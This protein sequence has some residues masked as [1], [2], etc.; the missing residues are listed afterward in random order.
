MNKLNIIFLFLLI[1][2][3]N[4]FAQPISLHPQNPHYFLFKGKPTIL[5]TSAEHYGA[6]L[7]ADFDYKKYLQTLRDEGMN[8][9]RIF[10]GSYAEVPE[11]FGIQN[12]SL[13]PAVGSFIAPWKRVDEPGLFKGEKKFDLNEWN[14]AF[15]E[16]L[17]DFISLADKLGI[18][19]EVTFFCSTYQD[20]IW[21]R[22]P[23]NP[24][25]NINNIPINLERQ[26]S[27]TIANGILTVFQQKLVQK[28]VTELNG[29]DNIFYE[30]QNEP[31]SDDPQKVMRLLKTLD[32][33]PEKGSWYK[34]AEMASPASLEWQKLMAKTVV[35]TEAQL[36]KKHIIAQNYT[37][38][39]HSL[40][41]VDPNISILN[42]HYA[43]P[44]AVWLN[45]G[46]NRPVS[47]D[48]SG[49]AGS[50]D[51]TYLRQAWQFIMAGGAVCNNL[52]YSFYVGKEDGIGTNKAPGGGSSMLRKQL[53]FLKGFI[54]SLDFVQM[55]PDFSTVVHAPGMQVQAISQPGFQYAI[56]FTGVASKSVKL[57]L[58]K[59]KYT[60]EYVS[61]YSGK[62]LKKG[63]FT[64]T[65]KGFYELKMPGFGEM[66]AL[67]IV[68]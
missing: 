27:N 17:N 12:N 45:Y 8:Y 52:D 37:N 29:F 58:P 28:L 25:N 42:F 16:R 55:K 64:K 32:P 56:A 61:P 33:E 10:V 7:N 6:V 31:W 9:T 5:I 34:W 20:F 49:F 36:P 48:E 51:S 30:I 47:F 1:I 40:D 62:T 21:E 19:V 39:M 41:V 4:S 38:F 43:W 35:E 67:K 3:L 22:N 53:A 57:N 68:R 23:F 2:C 63:F 59:G 18:V 26:K 65:K 13:A 14:P 54:E 44:E 66:V 24:G 15:F 11:S 60:F 50:S 46:W